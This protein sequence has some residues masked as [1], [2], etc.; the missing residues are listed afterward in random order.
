[1]TRK[2]TIERNI[3]LAF[4]FMKQIVKNPSILNDIKDGS[5][6]EFVDKDFSKKEN[7]RPAKPKKYFRVN[8]QFEAVAEPPAEYRTKKKI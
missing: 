5:V 7:K 3:G 6:I 1:M 4:D 8:T 2:E